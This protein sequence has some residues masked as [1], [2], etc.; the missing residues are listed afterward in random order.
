MMRAG[1]P[2]ALASASVCSAASTAVS[3]RPRCVDPPVPALAANLPSLCSVTRARSCCTSSSASPEGPCVA[4]ELL[5][6]LR[7][8]R[9]RLHRRRA[10]ADARATSER[11]TGST[12]SATVRRA[13]RAHRPRRSR[14]ATRAAFSDSTRLREETHAERRV[15]SMS[16]RSRGLERF[17]RAGRARSRS[18]SRQAIPPTNRVLD[19]TARRRGPLTSSAEQRRRS[20]PEAVSWR[21]CLRNPLPRASGAASSTSKLASNGRLSNACERE[22]AARKARPSPRRRSAQTRPAGRRWRQNR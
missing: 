6:F 9:R 18:G 10:P 14:R 17:A 3:Y 8:L 15:Q 2:R 12:A 7:L 5:L 20:G 22:I 1:A 19:L 13:H 21:A 4:T 16:V 11:A